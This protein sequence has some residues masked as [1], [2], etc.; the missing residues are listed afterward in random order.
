MITPCFVCILFLKSKEQFTDFLC[1]P[2][3]WTSI[4]SFSISLESWGN[5][6]NIYIYTHRKTR[7]IN[8][9]RETLQHP[10]FVK[11]LLLPSLQRGEEEKR[12]DGEIY[13]KNGANQNL[14]WCKGWNALSWCTRH[15]PSP[16]V[17]FFFMEDNAQIFI[18]RVRI[19]GY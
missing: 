6:K 9:L 4:K 5:I 18:F 15:C 7:C 1:I 16:K 11:I 17:H 10:I 3:L 13:N 19:L 14:Q 12:R 2:S 8:K